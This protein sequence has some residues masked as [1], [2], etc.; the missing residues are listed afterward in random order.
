MN[1]SACAVKLLIFILLVAV[2]CRTR[3]P[4]PKDVPVSPTIESEAMKAP[5]DDI[6]MVNFISSLLNINIEAS[7]NLHLYMLISQ[8][9]GVPHKLAGRDKN[10]IDC[11]AFVLMVY[12][13]VY[14]YN[15]NRTS[16]QMI[17]DVRIIRKNQLTEGDLVF[18]KTSGN[19]ISHVG[20]YLKDNKFVHV[21]SSRG[22]TIS[23]LDDAYWARTFHAA[24]RV[25]K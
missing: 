15:L 25:K 9:Y 14:N 12:S 8:W 13:K 19:R 20:I 4:P 11:S 10:G 5:V 2:S 3:I 16:Q 22:V 21:S 17:N 7:D 23:K 24:G 1:K 18:F 6:E